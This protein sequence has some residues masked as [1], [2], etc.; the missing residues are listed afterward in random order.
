[1]IRE[2]HGPCTDCW[3]H[4]AAG[5]GLRSSTMIVEGYRLR[6][7]TMRCPYCDCT[8]GAIET[9]DTAGTYLY[10]CWCNATRQ[11]EATVD[12]LAELTPETFVCPRCGRESWNPN[13][14]ENLYCGACHW[15]TADPNLAPFQPEDR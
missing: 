13:D 12:E 7:E 5:R 9:T 6:T 2:L 11:F 15:W 14:L 8:Y 1:M 10:R 3:R 4:F